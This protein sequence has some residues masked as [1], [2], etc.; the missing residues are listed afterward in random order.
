[1]SFGIIAAMML[2]SGS[3][4]SAGTPGW[5]ISESSGRVVILRSGVSQIAIRGGSLS[6]GDLVSTAGNSRAVIVRG[7]E[8]LVVSPNS[9]IRIAD[10]V[11]S[12]GFTQIIQDLGNIVFRIKK[13]TTPHFAVETP[14]LAAVVKGTTFSVTVTDAGTAVQ[15]TEGL[16]QV[17]TNDGGATHLV[18]PGDIGLVAAAMPLRL[19]IE[20]KEAQVIDSPNKPS[21]SP[22]PSASIAAAA[23]SAFAEE[24]TSNEATAAAETSAVN[25]EVALTPE[26][27]ERAPAASS[28]F[29]SVIGVAVSEGPVKLETVSGGLVS[30]NSTLLAALD[31]VRPIEQREPS[32]APQAP[33]AVSPP[34]PV[35]EISPP[36]P[37]VEAAPPVPV[38]DLAPPVEVVVAPSPAVEAPPTDVAEASDTRPVPVVVALPGVQIVPAVVEQ[39]TVVNPPDIPTPTSP[40]RPVVEA[41]PA[42][43]PSVVGQGN[44]N[45][46]AGSNGN[47][48]SGNNGNG[49]EGN[50]Q[51]VTNDAADVSGPANAGSAPTTASN[52]ATQPNRAVIINL[53]TQAIAAMRA[54]QPSPNG[55]PT[56]NGRRR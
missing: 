33:L 41:P 56:G 1:M 46:N 18:R 5:T 36:V 47:G 9:R 20:G 37:V 30:G 19:K 12:G 23:T 29:D 10:P 35:A 32:P 52:S 22:A 17:S 39:I 4:A 15:V 31:V 45:G 2:F 55:G 25:K 28:L 13:K 54:N 6:P 44:G 51:S 11:T 48:D 53:L 43:I 7:G 34:A 50:S 38:T 40:D 8:Y 42:S 26:V 21:A 16:V 27:K 49:N 14:Y 3:A 24:A